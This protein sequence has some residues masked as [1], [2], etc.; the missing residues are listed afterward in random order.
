M[1]W[2]GI[3]SEARTDLVIMERGRMTALRYITDCL[4]DNIAPSAPLVDPDF[5][6]MDD[7]ACPHLANLVRDYVD[8]KEKLTNT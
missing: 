1:V 7:N 4:V 5:I 3:S 2:G 6:F 8:E